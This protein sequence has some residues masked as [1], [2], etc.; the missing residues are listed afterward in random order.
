MPPPPRPC[1][2]DSSRPPDPA[3]TEPLDG[4]CAFTFSPWGCAMRA[5]QCGSSHRGREH[6]SVPRH[7]GH[8]R[9]HRHRVHRWLCGAG[10]RTR[11]CG[12]T[13]CRGPDGSSFSEEALDGVRLHHDLHR[14]PVETETGETGTKTVTVLD[15]GAFMADTTLRPGETL[16]LSTGTIAVMGPGVLDALP[17]TFDADSSGAGLHALTFTASGSA[18]C[19][20]ETVIE[21]VDFNVSSPWPPVPTPPF[22]PSTQP[23]T[24][25]WVGPGFTGNSFD[26]AAVA[27]AK[28]EATVVASY[29]RGVHRHHHP[30]RPTGRPPSCWGTSV[31]PSP[32][33][34]CPSTRPVAG[35][36]A[37]DCL[38]QATA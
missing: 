23:T 34:R 32:R 36:P 9:R 35:G 5:I 29:G 17:W 11:G 15:L 31:N 24:G 30:P 6:H 10:G 26:P 20:W 4:N 3:L 12:P 13:P 28:G 19:A 33:F 16:L 7:A 25:S 1:V 22:V 37:M 14:H 18:A 27:D 38:M 2:P 21:V 8:H